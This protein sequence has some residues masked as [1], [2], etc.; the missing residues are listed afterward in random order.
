MGEVAETVERLSLMAN[1]P[2]ETKVTV[3]TITAFLTPL[4]LGLL[5]RAFPDLTPLSEPISTLILA[6]VTAVATFVMAYRAKH[7]YRD[8]PPSSTPPP[9]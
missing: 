1:A 2:V 6:I 4:A 8:M 7:T 9:S 5:L 3:A